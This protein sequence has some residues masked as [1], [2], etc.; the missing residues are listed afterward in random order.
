MAKQRTAVVTGGNG[1]I[2]GHLV[3]R[4]KADGY[5]VRSV[6]IKQPEFE[7][8]AADEVVICDLSESKA[9]TQACFVNP[10]KTG[11]A[12]Q[13]GVDECYS[14]ACLMGGAGFIFTGDNDS[15]IMSNSAACNINTAE[16]CIKLGVKKLFYSSS[17]CMYPAE[18]QEDPS[19]PNCEESSAYPANPDSEY[20]WEKLFSERLYLAYARNHGLEVHIARFHNI[21]GPNG[22]WKGGKEKAPAAVCR[23]V[24]EATDEIEIWGSGKQTRSFLYIDA[25]IDGII[26]LMNND[27]AGPVNIGSEEMVTINQLVD[28]ACSF[29][30]KQLKKKHIVGPT[31]V[32][33]RNSDNRLINKKLGW[34][35]I[36]PLTDG[37]KKTYEWIKEQVEKS[38]Q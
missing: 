20:G 4:L 37:L 1:F 12:N 38:K 3:K 13:I 29:E 16:A 35:P 24:I 33:G 23:K 36:Y 2:G 15:Q 28:I 10:F 21:F 32:A 34:E 26:R 31:G 14:L 18:N 22:T 11:D 19:N 6:D 25:C 30:E 5:W 7:P 8:S 17:A 27:F 9:K